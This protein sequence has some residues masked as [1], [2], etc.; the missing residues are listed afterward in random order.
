M[1]MLRLRKS[2]LSQQRLC[3]KY[4]N[5]G[6]CVMDLVVHYH[7]VKSVEVVFL[8]VQ[9]LAL[10]EV[11]SDE[12]KILREVNIKY[13]LAVTGRRIFSGVTVG[14]GIRVKMFGID[15]SMAQHHSNGFTF[16]A[17]LSMNISQFLH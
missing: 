1:Q 16:M 15:V 3:F 10:V 14:A 8:Y 9:K 12:V 11:L 6:F 17:N 13:F 2:G 4:R 5:R 7:A